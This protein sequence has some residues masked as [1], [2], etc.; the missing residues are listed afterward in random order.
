[1][2]FPQGPLI[3][4]LIALAVQEDYSFGDVTSELFFSE[5]KLIKANIIARETLVFCGGPL[6]QSI[7]DSFGFSLELSILVHEGTEVTG[8][9]VLATLFGDIKEVLI[10]ERTILNFLQRM[11]GVATHTKR[12]VQKAQNVQILDT[13]KT[14]PGWR[15]LD[16]YAVTMGGAENHRMHLGDLILIKNNHVD[17]CNGDWKLLGQKVRERSNPYIPV[18]VEVR[19]KA[20]LQNALEHVGPAIIMFDNMNDAEITECYEIVKKAAPKTKI[21]ISRG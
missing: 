10:A 4:E 21:E 15:L 17:A 6:L 2:S 12:Y 5:V 8:D 14:L 7:I 1:M 11:S 16:K 19:N 18:E 13:R 9:T 20:E 3:S